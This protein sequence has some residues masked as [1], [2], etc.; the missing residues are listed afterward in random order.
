V[1]IRLAEL[2]ALIGTLLAGANMYAGVVIA[3]NANVRA[4][5]VVRAA[6]HD[7]TMWKWVERVAN[8]SDMGNLLVGHGLMVW[9]ILIQAGRLPGDV[10]KLAALGYAEWQVLAPPP[11]ME[12]GSTDRITGD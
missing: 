3:K 4:E 11:G 10:N 1:R 9:A 7:K 12:D 6:R 5:E 2:Y 8:G